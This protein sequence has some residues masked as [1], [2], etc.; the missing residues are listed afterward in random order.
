MTS[1]KRVQSSWRSTEEWRIVGASLIGDLLD[2]PWL[3]G[4]WCLWADENGTIDERTDLL[5]ADARFEGRELA[6]YA[7]VASRIEPARRRLL[8]WSYHD[9]VARLPSDL[10][11]DLLD[12]AQSEEW[13]LQEIRRVTRETIRRANE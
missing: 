1:Q 7:F 12:L 2:L 8:P 11:D 10:Q 9:A 13:T 3:F 5:K 6:H 4:D